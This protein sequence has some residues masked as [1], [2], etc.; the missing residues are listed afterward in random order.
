VKGEQD[1][2]ERENFVQKWRGEL[3]E[4]G[5]EGEREGGQVTND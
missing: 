1:G 5:R 2:C 4:R 3:Q